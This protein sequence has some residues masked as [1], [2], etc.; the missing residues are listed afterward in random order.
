IRFIALVTAS[1]LFAFEM[2]VPCHASPASMRS[3]R[4]GARARNAATCPASCAIPPA[5]NVE[6]ALALCTMSAS[7]CPWMSSVWR[8]W[9][10]SSAIA[11]DVGVGVTA[12]EHAHAIASASAGMKRGTSAM[13]TSNDAALAAGTYPRLVHR[14]DERHCDTFARSERVALDQLADGNGKAVAVR[15]PG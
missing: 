2:N 7:R 8:S 6:I 1:P 13:L 5:R 9:T 10:R 3:V 4:C 14:T 11:D 12:D 15:R